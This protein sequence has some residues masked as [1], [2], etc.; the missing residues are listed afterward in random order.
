MS[1][2]GGKGPARHS[3]RLGRRV[4]Q[5]AVR[6]LQWVSILGLP[7]SPT[8][9]RPPAVPLLFDQIDQGHEGGRAVDVWGPPSGPLRKERPRQ[10]LVPSGMEGRGVDAQRVGSGCRTRR[11]PKK[12]RGGWRGGVDGEGRTPFSGLKRKVETSTHLSPPS[13][14]ERLGIINYRRTTNLLLVFALVIIKE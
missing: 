14:R 8:A 1:E 12:W 4:W 10:R 13:V 7:D 2:G 6:T 9:A 11:T 3:R 5:S